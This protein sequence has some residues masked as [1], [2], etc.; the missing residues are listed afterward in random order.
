[1][2]EQSW[3][4]AA[5]IN[6][7]SCLGDSAAHGLNAVVQERRSAHVAHSGHDIGIG[8]RGERVAWL[9]KLLHATELQLRSD[10]WDASHSLTLC[11]SKT[12]KCG[13]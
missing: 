3:L 6:C 2:T 8:T 4:V 5:T 13:C 12:C 9:D 7:L 11:S 1:M 10:G